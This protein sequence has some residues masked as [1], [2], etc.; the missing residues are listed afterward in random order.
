M[1]KRI[2]IYTHTHTY[3]YT[4]TYIHTHIHI[5]I[6]THTYTHTHTYI[7]VLLGPLAVQQKWIQ[8]CKSTVLELKN[9]QNKKI[10]KQNPIFCGLGGVTFFTAS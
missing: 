6:Y 1:R 7:Y 5:Y 8:H 3:I 2:Y 9:L 10:V 4:Y